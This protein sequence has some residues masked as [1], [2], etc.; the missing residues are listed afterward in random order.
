MNPFSIM[1][2]GCFYDFGKFEFVKRKGTM[3]IVSTMNPSTADAVPLPL[4]RE[5]D[6][7]YLYFLQR[8][9]IAK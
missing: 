4:T 5:A 3:S 6:F 2:M 1:R 7:D 9:F 8:Y